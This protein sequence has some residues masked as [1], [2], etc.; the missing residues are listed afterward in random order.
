[1]V[2]AGSGIITATTACE[3]QLCSADTGLL[4]ATLLLSVI[5][6]LRLLSG[7]SMLVR[8]YWMGFPSFFFF[9]SAL[10]FFSPPLVFAVALTRRRLSPM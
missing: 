1:M 3:P 2:G 6:R 4:R 7:N 10:P 5:E 8:C 9:F